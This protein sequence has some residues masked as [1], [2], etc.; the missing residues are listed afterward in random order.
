MLAPPCRFA[1]FKDATCARLTR[2]IKGLTE[3]SLPFTSVE[4]LIAIKSIALTANYPL[5]AAKHDLAIANDELRRA[6][7]NVTSQQRELERVRNEPVV[8][9]WNDPSKYPIVSEGT[10]PFK[11]SYYSGTIRTE[12]LKLEIQRVYDENYRVY[13]IRKVWRQL[14]RDGFSVARCTIARLMKNMGL[15]GVLRGKKLRT[16]VSRREATAGD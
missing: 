11:T 16:T 9:S 10:I 8:K 13:G 6:G 5:E 2:W 14:Q 3:R 1:A 15:T 4:I 7:E 12:H